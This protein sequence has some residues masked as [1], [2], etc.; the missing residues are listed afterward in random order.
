MRLN[1]GCGDVHIDGYLNVDKEVECLPDKIQDLEVLPWDF[2]D[3]SVDQIILSHVLEHLGQTSQI[4]LSI[5]KELYRI[6]KAGAEIAIT[7][8]HPRHDDFL[9]DPTHVRPILPGQFHMYSKRQNKE[10]RD[11]GIANTPLADYLDV[12]FEVGD[13]TWVLDNK[14]LQRLQNGKM[15][16]AELAEK[17]EHE[18]NIIKE[19]QIQLTVIK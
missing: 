12:D 6:C 19:V 1:L 13:V 16:S 4:Y 14:W 3:N 8:P 10:W 11:Q 18:Y 7:V 17:A 15:T 2:R 5:I 9:T